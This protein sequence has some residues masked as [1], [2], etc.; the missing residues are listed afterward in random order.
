MLK[1][2]LFD[3]EPRCKG[4][5]AKF[6]EVKTAYGSSFPP[7][8]RQEILRL[9]ERLALVER[10]IAQV[11]AERNAVA[12]QGAELSPM[13][14]SENSEA[15]AAVKIATLTRLKGIGANDATLLTHEIF[16]RG[17]RNRRELASWVGMTPTPRASGVMERDQ[18]IG[19]D[20]PAWIR[21]QLIQMAWRLVAPSARKCALQVV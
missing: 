17:F 19:R 2:G 13:E 5:G 20:G 6:A 7:R 8:A 4:F 14:V 9:A 21:A 15:Q 3:L 11:E 1:H 10:Q 16:Y 12:R 18:G